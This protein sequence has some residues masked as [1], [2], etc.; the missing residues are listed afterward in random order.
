MAEAFAFWSDSQGRWPLK[1]GGCGEGRKNKGSRGAFN[2]SEVKREREGGRE[3]V[4]L[5]EA[6]C[7]WVPFFE[8]FG[9]RVLQEMYQRGVCQDGREGG[10][11]G[12]F[13]QGV[14]DELVRE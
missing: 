5:L 8:G 9:E 13:I 11:F 3:R 6:A 1:E 7:R 10:V 12:V 2:S 14:E 4:V